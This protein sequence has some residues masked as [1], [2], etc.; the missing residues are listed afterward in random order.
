MLQEFIE[1]LRD[2]PGMLTSGYLVL[3]W[4][5]PIAALFVVP[6]N[7]KPSS[8]T[9]WLMLIFLAPIPGLLIFLLL[10]NP[11]LS[12]RRRAKQKTMDLYVAE[13]IARLH[14]RE[15][16]RP[17]IDPPVPPRYLPFIKL[18][19]RLGGMPAF[20]GNHIEL[21][22]D[23]DQ[24]FVC[25]ARDV[26]RA[27]RFIHLEFYALVRDTSTEVVFTALE[28][29]A[30]RG[31]KVR[32]LL[33]HL[34]SR[35]YPG[36][37]TLIS[38]LQDAGIEAHLMLPVQLLDAEFSRIDLRNHR[39]I[40]VIDG[41]IGYTGSTNLVKSNYH[42]RSSII[43][44]ELV[45]RVT[46]PVVAQLEAIFIADWYAETEVIL[47]RDTPET[48]MVLAPA[49]GSALCQVLPSG[50]GH[51]F[52]NNLKLFVSLI[53]NAHHRVLLV[54]PY[55]VPDDSLMIAI[56]SAAQ[57]GIEVTLIN[58]AIADQFLVSHAQKS[59][60]EELMRA[61]VAIYLYNKPVMLHAKFMCID[62]DIA[63]IGSSNLDM[64]SFQL[65]LEVTLVA[66]DPPTVAALNA[67]T[68]NY[69]LRS[70]QLLQHEWAARPRL[71]RLFDNLA[72][73]TASLQ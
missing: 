60:Y 32:V 46:G 65:D 50:P 25:I 59:Y 20:S 54:N 16:L 35:R 31:V 42:N 64:R 52:D 73:L 4:L 70:R 18:N 19:D 3:A 14:A 37:H 48:V 29:A 9:A 27:R 63:V 28:R 30:A 22:A 69:L 47:G 51:D 33:D 17:V 15:D 24:T 57:R 62:D 26:D 7:R 5:I 58:S 55:F 61:G 11:K 49:V 56:V 12:R 2:L 71:K 10:G 72:R 44:E 43:Y 41:Q 23:Y 8:A 13:L 67:I 68:R 66:Y 38:R 53:H 1:Q 34:G 21:L 36:F 39:K 40:V 45:A 6:R